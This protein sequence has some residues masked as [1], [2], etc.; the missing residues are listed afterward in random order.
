MASPKPLEA[1]RMSAQPER[2]GIGIEGGIVMVCRKPY[3][4]V[5]SGTTA[6]QEGGSNE[7]GAAAWLSSRAGAD[8]RGDA[9]HGDFGRTKRL[10]VGQLRVGDPLQGLGGHRE[11]GKA[12]R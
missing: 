10:F 9:P 1:P 4:A 8:E 3:N 7:P 6:L 11:V 2:A 5:R 12:A